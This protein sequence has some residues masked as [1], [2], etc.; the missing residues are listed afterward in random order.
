MITGKQLREIREYR[1]LS[2]RDLAKFCDVSPQLIGQIEQGKKYFTENNYG[3][4]I[5]A[6]NVAF[7]EKQ[8][9]RL[10]KKNQ[11]NENLRRN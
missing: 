11:K 10:I 5:K 8:A 9:G 4:I 7:A 3:Q 6:L 2:L 1:E